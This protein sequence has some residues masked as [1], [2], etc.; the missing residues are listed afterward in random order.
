MNSTIVKIE[1]SGN[2]FNAWDQNGV[3]RTSE[4]L[5]STRKSAFNA[6]MALEQRSGKGGRVYWW[7]VPMSQF[8]SAGATLS[9]PPAAEV[10]VPTE[11][12]ELMNFISTSYSLKPK[13]LVMKELKWKYL[14]R[15]A[16]RGK[17]IMMTGQAGCG[18]TLAAKSL[19]NALDRPNFYFNLGA[20]QD[21][22]AT[23][24]GNTHFESKKGTYFSESLFVTAIQTPNAVI[25]L[26]ELTRAHPDAWNILMT[27]LDQ[28]QRY[29]RL[30]EASGQ[31]TIPVAEGVTFVATANIGNEYTST[32]VMDKALMDRFTIVEMDVLTDEE[33]FGLLTYM[34]PHVDPELLQ[35]VSEIAH[36]TRMESKSDSG[37]VSNGVSTRTSVEMAGLIYDG[38]G[39]DEASEVSIYPQFADD[40]GVDSERTFVKQLVQKYMNDGSDE[41]LFNEED[42]SS[43]EEF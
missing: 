13:D 28:G 2:R 8:D 36:T 35:A 37:K 27:V 18:K 12:A 34:F 25:L 7:K 17:N 4:I 1:K 29:L 26:D 22:R 40:G 14:I 6:G 11:H 3:K 30:D 20:T 33:E 42:D 38:F 24:I 16:V 39:L 23:L 5:T 31:E 21:P 19:I 15:S 9:A 10:N 32:R 41:N 43:D